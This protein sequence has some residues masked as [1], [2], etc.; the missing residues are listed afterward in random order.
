MFKKQ[1]EPQPNADQIIDM[2]AQCRISNNTVRADQLFNFLVQKGVDTQQITNAVN[3]RV[4]QLQ[5][6]Q[7]QFF[8]GSIQ[9]S[10][11]ANPFLEAVRKEQEQQQLAAF[12]GVNTTGIQQNLG[13]NQGFNLQPQ[14]PPEKTLFEKI[15]SLFGR[16]KPQ[17]GFTGNV[18]QNMNQVQG[19]N[20]QGQ[21]H[22][23]PMMHGSGNLVPFNGYQQQSGLADIIK[24]CKYFSLFC[25]G[26]ITAFC[27]NNLNNAFKQGGIGSPL[28]VDNFLY[29]IILGLAI[30]LLIAWV[31]YKKD[32]PNTVLAVLG[33]ILS[34]FGML[35]YFFSL[36]KYF[37]FL[38]FLPPAVM[39]SSL[40]LGFL[41]LVIF[42]YARVFG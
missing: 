19:L 18:P 6:S 38:K 14:L 16:E 21:V 31:G 17:Q 41:C 2:I 28:L 37:A 10:G 35:Q 13:V 22:G 36:S 33:G 11:H 15:L 23:Q 34:L 26:V 7:Q 8:G 32:I 1:Q 24:N 29:L 12:H 27:L 9:Q 30:F 42:A 39:G 25:I 20:A 3:Q 5:P 40:I 4:Q